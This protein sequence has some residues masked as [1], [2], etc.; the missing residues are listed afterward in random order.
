M[1]HNR[2][3][4]D[5]LRLM[6]P[7]EMRLVRG[8]PCG[9]HSGTVTL[10]TGKARRKRTFARALSEERKCVSCIHHDGTSF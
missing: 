6:R 2:Y 1:N 3:A 8:R 9:P 4:Y 5:A 7:D 10:I